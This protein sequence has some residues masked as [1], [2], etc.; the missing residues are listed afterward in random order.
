CGAQLQLLSD[1]EEDPKLT[2][3]Q[4]LEEKIGSVDYDVWYCPACLNADTERYLKPFSG[5]SECP[6]CGARTYKEDP[7]KTVRAAT[8]T[9]S[10]LARV[11]G[12][13]VS[14]NHKT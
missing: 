14:C 11:E 8:R 10:G 2:E 12:R 3:V 9:S 4:L 6:K 13:C 7:Q 5:F 1:Q